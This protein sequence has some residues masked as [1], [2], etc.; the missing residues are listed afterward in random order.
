MKNN[1]LLSQ[2]TKELTRFKD[3]EKAVFLLRFFK[4]GKG[5]Y[6]E[7]DVFLGITVPQQRKI[8]RKYRD[9][10][11]GDIQNLL[12]NK[13]HEIRLVALFI[14]VLKY[15]KSDGKGKKE[16]AD[17]Y[18]KNAKRVNNWDLVDSSAGYILGDYLLDKNKTVLYKLARA[19]NIWERRIAIIATQGFIRNNKF[20]DTLKIAEI[21]L[22]DK[23]DL[24]H[25]AVGW[26][27]REVGNRDLKT[28]VKFL[29]KHY[30]KMPRTML[31]YAIEK[32]E[33]SKK[34]F[35]MKK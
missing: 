34:E 8:A 16:I 35:Y 26:M 15:K 32:F 17:F 29:D 24:I 12:A 28:E 31:R 6:G 30:Q 21:L 14:L 2:I 11:L 7:G 18:L 5:Q 25:K 10:P 3:P 19:E 13:L 1:N 23:H 20:E 33:K 9:L 22:G 27:L 4:T